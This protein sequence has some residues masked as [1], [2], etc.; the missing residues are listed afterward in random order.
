MKKWYK[1]TVGIA[2]QGSGKYRDTTNYIYANNIGEAFQRFKRMPGVK[3]SRTPN[4][5]PLNDEES[6]ELERR[7]IVNGINLQR[8]RDKYYFGMKRI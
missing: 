2:H 1:V 8:A 6:V 4:I 3:R 7:I 5:E